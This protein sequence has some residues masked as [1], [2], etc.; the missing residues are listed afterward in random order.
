[1]IF[2]GGELH[3]NIK[4]LPDVCYSVTLRCRL[5]SSDE[6]MEMFLVHD[7]LSRKYPL[8]RFTLFI[9]YMPYARQDRVCAEGDAFS[10]DLFCRL[11]D[12]IKPIKIIAVDLHSDAGKR[13]LMD[14]TAAEIVVFDQEQIFLN[15]PTLRNK[16]RTSILVSPDR[17]ARNKTARLAEAS[18]TSM[19]VAEKTRDPN[20]GYLSGFKVVDGEHLICN[21]DLLIVD[22]ICDAGGTFIGLAKEL[23]KHSPKSLS[24]YVTHGIFSNGLK[25]FENIF[26]TIYTT[27]SFSVDKSKLESSVKLQVIHI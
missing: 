9:P 8:A 5:Q 24:L 3:C 25:V 13:C 19:I 23:M 11:L 21:N 12:V 18:F 7:I 2:S 20:T 4:E 10:F 22:D 17:G 26:E 1:M 14:N 15:N 16:A 27:D 6:I